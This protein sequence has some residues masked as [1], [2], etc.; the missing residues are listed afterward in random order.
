MT[1]QRRRQEE[2]VGGKRMFEKSFLRWAEK[3]QS[4]YLGSLKSPQMKRRPQRD[5]Y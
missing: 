4:A 5:A 1:S 2:G 3:H